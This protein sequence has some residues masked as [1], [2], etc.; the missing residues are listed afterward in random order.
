MDYIGQNKNRLLIMFHIC[1]SYHDSELLIMAIKND[2]HTIYNLF[3]N[4]KICNLHGWLT[5]IVHHIVTTAFWQAPQNTCAFKLTPTLQLQ[6]SQS[7]W[8][9]N[10]S[11]FKLTPTTPKQ[12]VGLDVKSKPSEKIRI[13][14]NLVCVLDVHKKKPQNIIA[15]NLVRVHRELCENSPW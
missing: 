14:T 13:G 7:A 8:M 3:F 4:P 15:R 10:P 5:L 1:W 9:W 12:P 11:A 2:D 6:N